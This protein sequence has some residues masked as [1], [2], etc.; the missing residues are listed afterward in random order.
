MTPPSRGALPIPGHP[1][2]GLAALA[3]A[4][5]AVLGGCGQASSGPPTRGSARPPATAAQPPAIRL[6]PPPAGQAVAQAFGGPHVTITTAGVYL[7]WSLS[8]PASGARTELARINM[9]SGRMEATRGLGAVSFDQAVAAGDSL[10]VATTSA[11]GETLLR[12]N[13]QTLAVTGRT[14]IGGGGNQGLAGPSLALAGGWL[15]VDA[16]DRLL[17]FSVP[18]GRL[19]A[20]VPLPG[21][22]TSTVAAN[23]SGTMLVVGEANQN[24]TGALARRDPTT[25]A[26]LHSSLPTLGIVAP[27]VGG[28]FDSGIW[29]S[30]V[31]GNLGYVERFTA[32]TLAPA[33]ATRVEGTNDVT[34]QAGDGMAW[35]FPSGGGPGPSFCA[36]P[37]SG[38]VLA[39]VVLPQ[40]DYILAVGPRQLFYAAPTPNGANDYVVTESLPTGCRIR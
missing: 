35:V 6:S 26:L 34:V 8:P 1:V 19:T 23:S 18:G 20:A 14:R 15:W 11:A 32:E 17:R 9:A 10:W 24:G 27:A 7:A 36:D 39:R 4:L 21:A 3:L 38:R 37:S 29:A 28:V 40:S 5:A 2:A 30:E 25:G 33:P 31:T 13:P 12:L 16:G 22:A